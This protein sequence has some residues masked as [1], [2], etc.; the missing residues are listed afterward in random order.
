M[1]MFAFWASASWRRPSQDEIA[2]IRSLR[3]SHPRFPISS[4]MPATVADS[5]EFTLGS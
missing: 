4:H 1:L 5:G 2:S 3:D